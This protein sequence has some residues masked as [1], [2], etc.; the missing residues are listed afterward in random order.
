MATEKPFARQIGSRRGR[1]RQISAGLRRIR[2]VAAIVTGMAVFQGFPPLPGSQG[3]AHAAQF[4]TDEI[5]VVT[6]RGRFRMVVEIADTDDARHQGLQFRQ[7]LDADRGMFFDFGK[8]E[9]VA[10]W[11]KNTLI[12]LD[13][14]F[15]D[16][17]GRVAR[18]ERN[19]E[20]RSLRVIPSGGPVRGVLEVNAGTAERLGIAKGARIQHPIFGGAP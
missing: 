12:P 3:E 11:M 14:I 8:T 9:Q 13:M 5:T 17:K 10:M 6:I 20:P 7:H 18:V 2:I 19:T 15:I 16:E 1:V 4:R